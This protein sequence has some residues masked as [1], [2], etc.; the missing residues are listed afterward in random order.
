MFFCA[1]QLRPS[2]AAILSF[3]DTTKKQEEIAPIFFFCTYKCFSSFST[4]FIEYNSLQK[5]DNYLVLNY[6]D[7]IERSVN[8]F[9]SHT[10]TPQYF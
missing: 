3:S 10:H 7:L 8:P 5:R 1:S 9:S 4:A 2:E 6:S